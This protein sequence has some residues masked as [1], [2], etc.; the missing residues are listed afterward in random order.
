VT[1]KKIISGAQTGADRA[2]LDAALALD[3][4]I[5]GWVPRG[6]KAEDG[7]IP[8]RYT[9]LEEIESESYEARTRMNV[10][11]SD[12][13]LILSHGPLHGGSKFTEVVAMKH[14]KPVLHVDLGVT[15]IPDAVI[16][17]RAWLSGLEGEVLNVA[18]PRAAMMA[19]L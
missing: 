7:V 2:S 18:G 10:L 16:A 9:G 14:E 1:I 13:T 19:R 5:G 6:R 11:Y 4:P 3:F 12:A 8:D 17:I 15:S